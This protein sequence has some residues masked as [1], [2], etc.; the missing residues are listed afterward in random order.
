MTTPSS[1]TAAPTH[2]PHQLA[3]MIV[4]TSTTLLW[5]AVLPGREGC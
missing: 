1:T 3:V 2:T 4:L 5:K